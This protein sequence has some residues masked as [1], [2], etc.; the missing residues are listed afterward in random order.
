MKEIRKEKMKLI[1]IIDN[2]QMLVKN[3]NDDKDEVIRLFFTHMKEVIENGDLT[4]LFVSSQTNVSIRFKGLSGTFDGR[5]RTTELPIDTEKFKIAIKEILGCK[6]D[7][8]QKV[9]E[10]IGVNFKRLHDFNI[11]RIKDDFEGILSFKYYSDKIQ[12]I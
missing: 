5:I 6:D 12:A 2:A 10:L 7:L 1:L 11:L 9:I 4:I 8:A 3:I